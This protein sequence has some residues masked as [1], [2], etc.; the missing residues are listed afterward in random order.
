RVGQDLE[1][2]VA[3][4]QLAAQRVDHAHEIRA[5]LERARDLYGALAA[6]QMSHNRRRDPE[7]ERDMGVTRHADRCLQ[8]SRARTREWRKH[9]AGAAPAVPVCEKASDATGTT[10]SKPRAASAASR[11]KK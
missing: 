2:R 3:G 5:I 11:V 10:C 7:C 9:Q 1:R 6:G 4:P 8:D